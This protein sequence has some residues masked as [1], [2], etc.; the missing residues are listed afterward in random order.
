MTVLSSAR[1]PAPKDPA[2]PE[3]RPPPASPSGRGWG[4]VAPFLV[5][6]LFALV[7]PSVYAMYLSLFQEKLI[8]GNGSSGFD[9]LP[10][11]ADRL[12]VLVGASGGAV[13]GGAGA[14][15]A[16]AC[17]AGRAGAGQR[18]AVRGRR[19]TGWRFSCRT[20]CRRWWRRLMWGFIYGTQFGLIGSS[21]GRCTVAAR[22]VLQALVLRAIGNIVT[23]EFVG[24]N[25]LIFSPRCGWC[26]A[27]CTRR[28]SWPRSSSTAAVSAC[29]PATIT[30]RR[31]RCPPAPA[32]AWRSWSR[33]RAGWTTAPASARP[34][35][36]SARCRWPAGNCAAG[37]CGRCRLTTSRRSRPPSATSRG[38]WPGNC[39]RVRPG[40]F[41]PSRGGRPVP[42]NGGLGQGLRLGQRLLPGPVLVARTAA[43]ALRARPRDPAGRQRADHS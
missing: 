37:T 31:W 18:A 17:A 1:R 9:E 3:R 5:V 26:R 36:S 10:A 12:A 2:G 14:G 41:R 30:T 32:A 15:H 7:A 20:R 8:G 39:G 11:G 43:G 40:G 28:R 23:W 38:R 6:F 16:G 19:C 22:S 35:G 25:M 13:P 29:S 27:S 21:S 24:Y 33:T 34:R 4:F 42:V